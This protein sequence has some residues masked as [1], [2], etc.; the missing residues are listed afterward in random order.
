MEVY[1][2]LGKG[3]LEIVNKGTIEYEVRNKKISYAHE[4]KR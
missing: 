2:S 3:L 4:K 1:R